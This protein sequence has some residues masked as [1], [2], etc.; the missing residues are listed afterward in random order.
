MAPMQILN[1]EHRVARLSSTYIG[2]N[3][4]Q[5]NRKRTFQERMERRKQSRSVVR[6]RAVCRAYQV[7]ERG[8][9]GADES[10]QVVPVPEAADHESVQI[11]IAQE[12]Q[13]GTQ[14]L[15]FLISILGLFRSA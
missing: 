2:T 1:V 14:S 11:R 7:S 15:G 5:W 8:V 10:S 13:R 9:H 3:A 6:V 12:I 4:I